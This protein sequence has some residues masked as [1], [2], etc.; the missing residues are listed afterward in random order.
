[1]KVAT[2]RA[3]VHNLG[4]TRSGTYATSLLLAGV[5]LRTV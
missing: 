1:M 5:D 2:K 4:R 3:G